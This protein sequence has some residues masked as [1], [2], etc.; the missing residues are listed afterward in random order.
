MAPYISS[1]STTAFEDLIK[2][3]Y[4]LVDKIGEG[5][6]G[7]VY[8]AINQK[9]E[10]VAIKKISHIKDYGLRCNIEPFIM[11]SLSH[12]HL[13]HCQEIITHS[14]F[15]C[16]VMPLAKEDIFN[17][18]KTHPST[19]S[20]DQRIKWCWQLIQAVACLHQNNIIHGDIKSSNCLVMPDMSLKLTDFTLSIIDWKKQSHTHTVCTFTHRPPELFL[21]QPWSSS[22][23]IWSLGCTLYEIIYGKIIFASQGDD[24]TEEHQLNAK[25]LLC[26]RDWANQTHQTLSSSYNAC[27]TKKNLKYIGPSHKFRDEPLYASVNDLILSMLRINP[28]ER[29]SIFECM[30]H[31]AFYPTMSIYP[32]SLNPCGIISY[33]KNSPI[34]FELKEAVAVCPS[35]VHPLIIEFFYYIDSFHDLTIDR[36]LKAWVAVFIIVKLVHLSITSIPPYSWTE[37][38]NTEL[39]ISTR[40]KWQF[41]MCIL[42][43]AKI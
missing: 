24:K 6:Y 13:I 11:S 36:K 32:Y 25:M 26:Y 3:S 28:C 35:Y 1:P 29:P 33:T 39:L 7:S 27:I 22:I 30:T 23:D 38:I 8:K 42:K 4:E 41:P 12:K 37:M 14:S 31:S 20:F 34:P 17:Y 5:T 43:T 10:S 21:N 2:N 18:I 16:I 9:G 15:T 40:M 19:L